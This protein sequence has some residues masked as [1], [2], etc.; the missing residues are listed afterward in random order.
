M[1]LNGFAEGDRVCSE[2]DGK[3]N[4]RMSSTSINRRNPRQDLQSNGLQPILGVRTLNEL[5]Q[6]WHGQF[7]A[8]GGRVPK[9]T[10][11]RMQTVKTILPFL[12]ISER[13]SP[14]NI[15]IRLAGSQV[16]ELLGGGV[17]G[18]NTLDLSPSGQR[19]AIAR[20]YA[21]IAETP[22]GFYIRES[23][24]L[25]DNKS[26]RLEAMILPMADSDGMARYYI[27]AYHFGR[28]SYQVEDAA[29]AQIVHRQFDVFGY[30]D[31]GFGL[32][33]QPKSA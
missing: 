25:R 17:T 23:L 29:G 13:V 31:L 7:L 14:T 27:G 15:H 16:E 19:D 30:I 32:P 21:Y 6:A 26:S 18:A 3:A 4:G 5:W 20:V 28:N 24:L 11:M 1:M 9:K 10:D 8:A 2:A 33:P 12:V 22:A